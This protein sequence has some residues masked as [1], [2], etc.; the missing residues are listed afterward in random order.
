MR[1]EIPR[2]VWLLGFVSLLM[3]V[4]SEMIHALLPMFM[5]GVLGAGMTTVGLV[6]GIAESAALMAKVF[7][8][9]LSDRLGRRKPLALTGYALGAAAKPLFALAGGLGTVLAA[10]FVDRIGKGIRGAPRDALLADVT[11]PQVR[12][13]AFGLRRAL[14]VTGAV[15]GPLLATALMLATADDFRAVFWIAC[16]PAL[17]CVALLAL[18]VREP[19]APATAYRFAHPLGRDALRMLGPS[20]WRIVG[21]GTL[22]TLAR[23]SEAFLV[24]RA[25]SLGVPMAMVPLVMVTMNVVDAG[26]SYPLGR[27]A[28]RVPPRALLAV[29]AGLLA[30][31]DALLALATAWPLAVAGVVLWGLHLA[32]T[33]GVFAA[34]IAQAAPAALRGTAYGAFNFASGLAML[35][36]SLAAGVLW[37]HAGAA[38]T[39]W[40]GLAMCGVTLVALAPAAWRTRDR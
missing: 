23:F 3:D 29:G 32:A 36:A 18:G 31:A 10:R 8:G 5:V 39:F 15:V 20:Y 12:G 6:E 13:A 2:T 9:A 24:L 11:P 4:S 37:D 38:A 16:L 26:A 25:Q 35:V 30:G 7:S 40:A 27:L 22:F 28:D 34:M 17:A 33:E 21:L 1:P 19:A 14:D